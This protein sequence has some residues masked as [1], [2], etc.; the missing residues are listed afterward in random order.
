MMMSSPVRGWRDMRLVEAG[1]LVGT[2]ELSGSWKSSGCEAPRALWGA[3]LV[4]RQVP[5]VAAPLTA[6]NSNAPDLEALLIR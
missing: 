2:R 3:Q 4:A 1:I 5:S 6:A